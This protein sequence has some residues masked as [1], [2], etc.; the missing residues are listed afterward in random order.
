M[1]NTVSQRELSLFPKGPD[2]GWPTLTA[3]QLTTGFLPQVGQVFRT[4]VR[5]GVPFEMPP[6]VLDGIELG[7]VRRES[8]KDEITGRTLD[9]GAHVATAMHRQSIPDHQQRSGN[10]A[11]EVT[12]KL[13][14]LPAVDAPPIQTEV[15]FPPSDARDDREFAPRMTEHQLGCS[16]F[17]RP[18]AHDIG[19]FRQAAF[20]HKDEGATFLHRLFLARATCASSSGQ[21]WARPVARLYR[22]A[23]GYSTPSAPAAARHGPDAGAPRSGGG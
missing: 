3:P 10:L 12:E 9:I 7:G 13:H 16:P 4:K 23:V 20:V 14:R 15:E 21:S 1:S 18:S 11:A 8:R 22:W 5:Q 17:G 6:D 2:Q 19:S